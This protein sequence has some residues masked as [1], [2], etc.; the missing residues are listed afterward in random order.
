[1]KHER[2]S[3]NR[4]TMQT[5][6]LAI[7]L[8]SSADPS[9]STPHAPIQGEARVGYILGPGLFLPPLMLTEDETEAILLGLRYVDQ[10][11]D[12]VLTNAGRNARA[13]I[14]SVLSRELQATVEAPLSVPGADGGT[15]PKNA[16]SLAVLRSA[17]RARKR[18]LIEYAGEQAQ[19]TERV[20]W[21]IQ[22]SFMDKA[23]VVMAWC[24][25]RTAFRFFRTDRIRAAKP[26]DRYPASRPDPRLLRA[27]K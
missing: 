14:T 11:G 19:P 12:E 7:E 5:D 2:I 15:F 18:I 22:L 3:T 6:R 26:L 8:N 20:I 25:L 13:K 27:V 10:R 23:R 4:S 9:K 16:V 24:E 1:M 21:P 17:I